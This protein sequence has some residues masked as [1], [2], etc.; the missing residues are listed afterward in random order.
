MNKVK[1]L[2]AGSTS[3][4]VMEHASCNV[5]VVKGYFLPEQ[6]ASI[7][8]VDRLEEEERK[9]RL[10]LDE[11]LEVDALEHRERTAAHIGAV[12]DEET[13]RQRRIITERLIDDRVHLCEVLQFDSDSD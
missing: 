5:V 3:K 10:H 1:R 12:R 8:E 2:L 13:E 11:D 4:Y 9:R 7:K 6:H